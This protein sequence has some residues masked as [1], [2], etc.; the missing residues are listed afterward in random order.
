MLARPTPSEPNLTATMHRFSKS[1][2]RTGFLLAAAVA[3][4]CGSSQA[5]P[6]PY[7]LGASTSYNHVSNVYRQNSTPSSDKV[8]SLGLLAGIDQRFGRQRL[9][10]DGSIQQ[11]RYARN[12]ALNNHSYSLSG[13]LDWATAGNVSGSLN[14]SSSRA[15]ASYNTGNV[16]QVFKK[17]EQENNYLQALVRVGV[18]TRFSLEASLTH[19]DQEFSEPEY[20]Q[21]D[22]RQNA[23]SVGLV[24]QPHDGLRLGLAGRFT[25]G[26]YPHYPFFPFSGS[27]R[28]LVEDPYKRR[29]LDLTAYWS[30]SGA[31]TFDG[32]ISLT[33][34]RRDIVTA[35]DFSGV[36]GKIGWAWQP[37]ARLGFY[38][39]VSRDNGQ[40]GV[41]TSTSQPLNRVATAVQVSANYAV[42]SKI[43]AFAGA[44][45]RRSD[46]S[47]EGAPINNGYD[48]DHGYNAG[49]K[50]AYSRSISV[51][52][53][54][55][56]SSRTSNIQQYTYDSR[57][58]GCAAQALMY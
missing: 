22:Y 44:N 31:S 36:T 21:L 18:I 43:S 19:T 47:R 35:L 20:Q 33:R 49:V 42:T 16:E 2:R 50:W 24:Y 58:Y 6:N 3:I 56:S 39:Q 30:P 4:A 8:L 34:V 53:Q 48:N 26:E 27:Q 52:C 23:A 7:Y 13:G 17:V 45:L 55:T 12:T 11:N 54:L 9:H 46:S 32:R 40:D 1:M 28:V 10:F 5:E 57:S 41:T 15:L 37:T 14:A 25:K 51:S 29:D 38:T